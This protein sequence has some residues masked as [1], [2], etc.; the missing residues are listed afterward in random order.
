[1]SR[2]I[3]RCGSAKLERVRIRAGSAQS[4]TELSAHSERVRSGAG[5]AQSDAKGR[6]QAGRIRCRSRVGAVGQ[7]DRR[8]RSV[9]E[10]GAGRA[11]SDTKVGA[12]GAYGTS[13]PDR[14]SRREW[15]AR[16]SAS[17]IGVG[18]E[19]FG[20]QGRC[21]RSLSDVGVAAFVRRRRRS[22]GRRRRSVSDDGFGGFRIK[23]QDFKCLQVFLGLIWR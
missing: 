20:A 17:D 2:A 5:S 19:H 1:V 4:N 15:S 7:Q 10:I 12:V 14:R 18:T 3:L 6:A 23:R 16:R 21:S 13:A 8:S 11:Q 9:S 22:R